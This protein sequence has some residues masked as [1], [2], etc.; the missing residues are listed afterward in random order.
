[1][2]RKTAGRPTK[3]DKETMKDANLVFLIIIIILVLL[4][5]MTIITVIN[6]EI[7]EMIKASIANLF[8]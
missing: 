2:A 5:S 8:K 7:F 1:M 6:P 4:L 3:I